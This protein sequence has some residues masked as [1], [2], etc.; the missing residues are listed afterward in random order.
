MRPFPPSSDLALLIGAVLGDGCITRTPNGRSERLDIACFEGQ[1]QWIAEVARL[2][3]QFFGK[4]P[5]LYRPK[6]ARCVHV[7]LYM[8]GISKSPALPAGDKLKNGVRIPE[9]VFSRTE[10]IVRCLRG[11]LETDG[12]FVTNRARHVYMIEFVSRNPNLLADC[13][14]AFRCLGFHP[15]LGKKYV[16]LSQIDEIRR[17]S[18]LSGFLK[19][20]LDLL[21]GDRSERRIGSF[22]P[23]SRAGC[24]E[25]VFRRP[26]EVPA[27]GKVYCSPEHASADRRVVHRPTRE[28]LVGMLALGTSWTEIGRRYGVSDN[29]VRKWA[30]G[31]GIIPG[32]ATGD[33]RNSET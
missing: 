8:A 4:R 16:R 26:S 11:L 28:E 32:R 1:T 31:Y 30:R 10:F 7:S 13:A 5:A 27:S 12:C 23:C 24:T 19:A 14:R 21:P 25:R 3:E 29:A 15:T 20:K 33:R 17:F 6:S 18:L 2:V 22:Y 9:W